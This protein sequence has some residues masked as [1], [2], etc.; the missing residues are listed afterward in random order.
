M[1]Q[2]NHP[3]PRKHLIPAVLARHWERICVTQQAALK[4]GLDA[5]SLSSPQKAA[6]GGLCTLHLTGLWQL[7]IG[8]LIETC[9]LRFAASGKGDIQKFQLCF[10]IAA[11][12]VPYRLLNKKA[13]PLCH[14]QMHPTQQKTQS[15]AEQSSWQPPVCAFTHTEA[16][17]CLGLDWVESLSV[18][19]EYSITHKKQLDVIRW[20]LAGKLLL[21]TR[22]CKKNEDKTKMSSHL[23]QKPTIP[24]CQLPADVARLEPPA[25]SPESPPQQLAIC[26]HPH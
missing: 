9:G 15:K 20:H 14:A 5:E 10:A 22:A 6:A 2:Q 16:V 4:L 26:S 19:P 11:A 1:A 25:S 18:L 7:F 23:V 12:Q 17:P 8:N 3:V 24:P 21:R 13:C